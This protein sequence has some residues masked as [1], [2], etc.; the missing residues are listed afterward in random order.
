MPPVDS[1][2]DFYSL[3]HIK[4][5]SLQETHALREKQKQ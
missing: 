4:G 5:G 2:E 1:P 3:K